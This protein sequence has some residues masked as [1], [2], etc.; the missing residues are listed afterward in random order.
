MGNGF[1]DLIWN[2]RFEADSQ[3]LVYNYSN[4]GG[5]LSGHKMYIS[6]LSPNML[7]NLT[8]IWEKST[9]Y[10]ALKKFVS[11]VNCEGEPTCTS[12]V[13]SFQRIPIYMKKYE[14]MYFIGILGEEHLRKFIDMLNDYEVEHEDVVMNFFVHSLTEDARTGLEDFLR[15]VSAHGMT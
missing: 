14:Q 15:I 2:G 10:P 5:N 4:E 8:T 7:K 6:N 13:A 9:K 1:E 11:Y 12:N 3:S